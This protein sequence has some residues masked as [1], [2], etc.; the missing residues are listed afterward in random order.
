MRDGSARYTLP[1]GMGMG[2]GIMGGVGLMVGEGGL[3][4][5][6]IFF[7]NIIPALEG[8]ICIIIPSIILL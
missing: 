2:I 8:F 7:Y 1:I 3:A 4:C 6:M 5:H